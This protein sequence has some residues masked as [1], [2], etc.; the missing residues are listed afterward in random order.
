MADIDRSDSAASATLERRDLERLRE[1]RAVFLAAEEGGARRDYWRSRRDLE[2]YDATFARR[3]AWKWDAVLSELARRRAL[4]RGASVLDFGCGTAVASRRYLAALGG[5]SGV[6][7]RLFDRSAEA[8]SFAREALIAEH[9]GVEVAIGVEGKLGAPGVLLVSHVLGELDDAAL[10]ELVALARASPATI[11]VEPGSRALSRRLGALRDDLARDLD[12]VAP[13]T[14]Q[15]ACGMLAPGNERGWCHGFARPPAEV[16]TSP[17]WRDVARELPLDL[18]ALPYSFL[19]VR[20]REAKSPDATL[21]R[22][23]GR[24]RVE[25][26]RALLD[27]CDASG[28]RVLT[29]LQRTDRALFRRLADFA[30]EDP[31]VRIEA[32]GARVDSIAPAGSRATGERGAQGSR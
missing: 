24:P 21:A 10:G 3:I 23:L 17:F 25:K 4:P 19:A 18:R 30:G 7:V 2:L 29:L 8:A 20:R 16:F 14:H 22:I 31:L 15:A 13:C 32:T 26:G 11:W 6:R 28:V 27:V 1:L 5:A 12:V 9:A